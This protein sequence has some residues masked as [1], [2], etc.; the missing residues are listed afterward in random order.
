[1]LEL[2]VSKNMKSM[3]HVKGGGSREG[4]DTFMSKTKCLQS[5]VGW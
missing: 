1:M 3:T 4:R 2:S 5:W